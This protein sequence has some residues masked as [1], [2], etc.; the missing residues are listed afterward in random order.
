VVAEAVDSLRAT[1][2][3]HRRAIVVETMGR[4]AGWIALGG[5]LAGYADVILIPERP[6][7]LEKLKAHLELRRTQGDRGLVIVVAEGAA[8]EGE[9]ARV[10]FRVES[11]PQTERY[12]G[13]A[14]MLAQ[15]IEKETPWEART[16]VLGHLQ[17]ARHPTT[18]DRF[19]TLAMGVEVARMAL[20][21]KWGWAAVYR[22]GKV[23][24]AP[25]DDLMKPARL[26]APDHRWVLLAQALGAFI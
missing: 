4:T 9:S 12:G 6:F 20:E 8:A 25:I 5:G 2:F 7:Q 26:V 16:V 19:L 23:T 24:R 22:D 13:V 1:A 17:R 18:T 15:W 10:A 21:G 3:A 11:S 14:L